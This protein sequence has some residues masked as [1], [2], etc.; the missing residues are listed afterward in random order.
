[1][2]EKDG[3]AMME[4]DGDAMME[5]DGD[6]MM[7]KDGDAMME[8]DGDA[9]ME[10][11]GDAMM[12]KDGDAMM[13]KDGDAMMEKDGDAM[14]EKLPDTIVAPHFVDASPAHGDSLPQAPLELVLNFNFNLHPDSA[15]ALTRDGSPVALGPVTISTDK[16]SMRAAIPNTPGDGVYQVNYTACWPD[17]SCHE[18]SVAFTVKA[19]TASQFEDLRGQTEVT[20]AMVDG[21]RFEP[22]RIMISP[23][24]TVTWVNNS[25]LVHFVNT[26]P[27]PSHNLR[28]EL[29]S[30]DLA[31]N[32][33]HS[34]T[35]KE[36]GIWG[37]HC[38]A[39][40]NLGMI[41][42]VLVQ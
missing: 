2:M 6:A 36:A 28:T 29:N 20:V 17:G 21:A 19:E 4:K 1:M 13:E 12:E 14:M 15:I 24:T 33:K 7:E 25:S 37:Y 23:G 39:H 10:K 34:Y 27:H 3:D 31:T 11:D 18:G 26:D 35:F 30:F 5:K 42:Q 40:H 41:A 9:M 8:K 32:G 16:L 38:S 22:A